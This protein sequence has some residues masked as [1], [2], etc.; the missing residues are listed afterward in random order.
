MRALVTGGAGFIGSHVVERLLAHGH[1]VT[2]LDDL[3]TGRLE[4]IAAGAKM[5]RAD[6]TDPHLA[7]TLA[8]Y[9][10]DAV[11]HHAAQVSVS[12]SLADP[13]FDAQVNLVGTMNVLDYAIQSGVSRFIFASSVAVYGDPHRLPAAEDHPAKPLSPYAVSKLA[14]EQYLRETARDTDVQVVILR[15]ANVYGPRQSIRGEPGVACAMINH[16]LARTP[17]VI[18]GDGQQKRDFVYVSDVAKANLLALRNDT[19]CGVYNV[20]TGVSTTI[21]E[22]KRLLVG[23]ASKAELVPA[24]PGDVRHSVLDIGAIQSK[25]R[26]RPTVSLAAGLSRTWRYYLDPRNRVSYAP[27]PFTAPSASSA[28]Y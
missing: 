25:M 11:I 2:V 27:L 17:V 3:S 10:F 28:S 5:I 18:H 1:S 19:P 16:I 7:R 23:S 8:R 22:L 24:R 21:L 12:R 14:A 26:W 13:R 9:K 4:N 20:G 15:Y 6:V